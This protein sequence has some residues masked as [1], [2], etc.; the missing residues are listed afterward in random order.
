[1][2]TKKILRY[3]TYVLIGSLM[4]ITTLLKLFDFI[5]ISSDWFWFITG[6]GLVF[7]GVMDLSKDKLFKKKYK[8]I[9]QEDYQKINKN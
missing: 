7:E 5:Q 1:M 3:E 2:V 8:V 6:L 4:I 9:S